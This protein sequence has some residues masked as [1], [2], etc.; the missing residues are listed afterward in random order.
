MADADLAVKDIIYS[1]FGH[2]GQKCSACSL[3]II[4]SELYD[5]P[6][7]QNQLRDAASSLFV[8][9]PWDP[10]SI[11][12]PLIR[13]PGP[14]L[15]RALT[16][17]EPGE[18][19]LLKPIC[20]KDNANLWSPGIKLGVTAGSFTHQTE[21]FG[22]VLGLMRAKDLHEAIKFANGTPYGLTTGIFTL[23]PREKVLW[24]S[25]IEAGNCYVNRSITGAIV[26]RQPFGGCKA[27]SFGRGLKAGGPNYLS[28]LMTPTE[29]VEE[30]VV[31]VNDGKLSEIPPKLVAIDIALQR[32]P[33]S[34]RHKALW[35]KSAQS[36]AY[37]WSSY[38]QKQE[39]PSQLMG[40]EN[41]LLYK[42]Y[43]HACIRMSA[44][45]H[46][47]DLFRFLAASVIVNASLEISGH[48]P[49]FREFV[50]L[51]STANLAQKHH[52]ILKE[53]SDESFAQRIID[54][55]LLRFRMTSKPTPVILD[56]SASAGCNL[57]I[58]PI[59][60]NGRIELLNFLREVSL[61]NDYHRYGNLYD[62]DL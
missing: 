23:D 2:S 56:A 43:M 40:Q 9:S 47:I 28:Q 6:H 26:Q 38:F 12:T 34:E 25:T 49:V 62:R 48:G 60:A 20:D 13:N 8:G 18:S 3:A 58:Q 11:V 61:S 55:D 17:L 27:S 5:S 1:A 7:F 33:F 42:P 32:H 44:D 52:V 41:L 57:I 24:L 16:T 14:E 31:Q 37:Y 10:A 21:L 51:C 35:L 36:Y 22:P 50:A 30:F 45:D 19:W 39:D 15:L 59:L 54:R 29:E 53:E 46:L 4:E